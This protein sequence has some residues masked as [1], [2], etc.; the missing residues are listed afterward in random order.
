[1][2]LDL[3]LGSGLGVQG[4]G[5]NWVWVQRSGCSMQRPE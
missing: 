4:L 1:M 3:D 5:P 2:G